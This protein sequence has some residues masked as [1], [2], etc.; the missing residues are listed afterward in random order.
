[1][2]KSMSGQL[3]MFDPTTC[4]G[5]HNAIS[6]PESADGVMPCAWP[7]GPT[8]PPSGPARVPASRF[9][10]RRE[11]ATDGYRTTGICGPH[12]TGLSLQTRLERCLANRLP[13]QTIGLQASA[14]TWKPWITTSERRF[15]RLSLSAATMRAI[16]CTLWAT[17]TATANQ[18][19][20]SMQK[21]PGCRGLVVTPDAWRLRMG[22]PREWLSV[23]LATPL[24][25]PLRRNS[26][27]HTSNAA[28]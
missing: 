3:S 2:G 28:E 16:G 8:M 14:M 25:R 6:S 10:A 7:D 13:L 4:E 17:P 18:S 27:R 9:R 5:S 20:P 15:S 12:G 11:V 26:S 1:M 22:Y 24:S 23:G 19:A 21:H